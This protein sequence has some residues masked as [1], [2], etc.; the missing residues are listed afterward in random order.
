MLLLLLLLLSIDYQLQ[1]AV[2][3]NLPNASHHH[4]CWLLVVSNRWWQHYGNVIVVCLFFFCE[5]KAKVSMRQLVS[6]NT[7]ALFSGTYKGCKNPGILFFQNFDVMRQ[8]GM[9]R[10]EYVNFYDSR[11]N[12]CIH[13]NIYGMSIN[14]W[15][16]SA[17][18]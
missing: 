17:S 10:C 9:L 2:L 16:S 7:H 6:T 3:S 13:F 14:C 4:C 1:V 18:C 15:N 12:F 5:R 8:P 11:C